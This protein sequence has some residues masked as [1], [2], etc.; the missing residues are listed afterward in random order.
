MS[1]SPKYVVPVY[2]HNEKKARATPLHQGPCCIASRVILHLRKSI[3]SLSSVSVGIILGGGQSWI[4]PSAEPQHQCER[5][6]LSI[7]PS[8]FKS[9]L[10]EA[11]SSRVQQGDA[12]TASAWTAEWPGVPESAG[13]LKAE[14]IYWIPK[15]SVGRPFSS[16]RHQ[17]LLVV[18]RFLCSS[19]C[20]FRFCVEVVEGEIVALLMF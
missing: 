3:R 2:P 14:G 20:E 18:W 5:R 10:C 6:V 4:V 19:R 13:A 11:E 7:F 17:R 8:R 16:P 15:S 9:R 1:G 12:E